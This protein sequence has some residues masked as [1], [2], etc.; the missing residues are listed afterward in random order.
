MAQFAEQT[1][2]IISRR[3]DGLRT[4]YFNEGTAGLGFGIGH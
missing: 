3:L 1:G 4:L 2:W